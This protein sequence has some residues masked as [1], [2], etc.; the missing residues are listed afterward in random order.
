MARIRQNIDN[1]EAGELAALRAGYAAMQAISDNRGYNSIAGYH[2]VPNWFCYHH[3]DPMM[4]VPWHRGYLLTFE[5]L[6]RDRDPS[7]SLPYWDWS[8]PISHQNGV[9]TAFSAATDPA[10]V[11]NPLLKSLINA[12]TATPPVNQWTQ[13]FPGDPSQLPQPGDVAALLTQ[14]DFTQFSNAL[15]DMHDQIHGWTGGQNGS[16]A[17]LDW[18]AY[19]PVF[20]SHHCMIDR[21]WARWQ[22]VNGTNNIPA[23]LLTR[24]LRGFDNL[25]VAS[26][27]DITQ[28][29]YSYA[30]DEITV[31]E[32]T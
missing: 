18:A 29:G 27:V 15:Q 9:P 3:E 24:P 11:A 28:L 4:F 5:N 31:A 13:R 16:M 22:Q 10:N 2:G 25:T 26:V 7:L 30:S 1:Y 17:Q 19:D 14:S 32:G 23:T 8:S 21:I 6:L 20:F 12:P